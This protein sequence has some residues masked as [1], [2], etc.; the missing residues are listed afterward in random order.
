VTRGRRGVA[1]AFA[2]T[3]LPRVFAGAEGLA[4]TAFLA[5][6]FGRAAAAARG[7]ALRAGGFFAAFFAALFGAGTAF[8]PPAVDFFAVAAALFFVVAAA[9]V[10]AAAVAFFT[11]RALPG[12]G[13]DD[14]RAPAFFLVL[15]IG[16]QYTTRRPRRYSR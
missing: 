1:A 10:G 14:T 11:P 12:D 7:A 9:F 13:A 5:S 15:A 16:G 3:P 2:A 8:A 6:G 4:A